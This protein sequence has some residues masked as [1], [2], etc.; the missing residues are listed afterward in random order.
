MR[1]ARFTSNNNFESEKT[2]FFIFVCNCLD[3]HSRFFLNSL[4]NLSVWFWLSSRSSCS[5][6]E[7]LA[8]VFARSLAR[9]FVCWALFYGASHFF[10]LK[11]QQ[12][13]LDENQF[14]IKSIFSYLF[15]FE[16]REKA[17]PRFQESWLLLFLQL[18]M[19]S[20]LGAQECA[21]D[22]EEKKQLQDAN[23]RTLPRRT[24]ALAT[25]ISKS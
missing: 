11:V 4:K 3:Y 9:S 6:F 15:S 16:K 24:R 2:E 10:L 20:C 18:L 13:Y 8:F 1:N 19:S 17:S 12:T 5:I 7:L 14:Q 22:S 21:H 25:R 23:G